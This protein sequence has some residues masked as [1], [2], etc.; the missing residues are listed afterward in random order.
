MEAEYTSNLQKALFFAI[1]HA[2]RLPRRQRSKIK[3][4]QITEIEWY[5]SSGKKVGP[6]ADQS[7]SLR[8]KLKN[9][10]TTAIKGLWA[11]L[12]SNSAAVSI[13][14]EYKSDFPTIAPGQSV[15]IEPTAKSVGFLVRFPNAV[16]KQAILMTLHLFDQDHNK[17][18]LF[19]GD[20]IKNP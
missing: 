4:F 6:I 2:K 13:D 9:N 8:F 7:L 20:I 16:S 15:K 18:E 14:S 17:W 11:T 12:S 1:S 3:R 19:I 10:S 5:N